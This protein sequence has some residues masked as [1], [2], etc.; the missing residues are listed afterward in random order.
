MSKG[1]TFVRDRQ[2]NVNI[3]VGYLNSGSWMLHG[4]Q[5]LGC[6]TADLGSAREVLASVVW[7][8]W[9]RIEFWRH[10]FLFFQDHSSRK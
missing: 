7:E 10:V 6:G 1:P 3:T 5:G 8:T 4:K 9:T 2:D